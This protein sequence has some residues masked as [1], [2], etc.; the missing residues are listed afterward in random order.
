[1]MTWKLVALSTGVMYALYNTF[2]RLAAGKISDVYGALILE[3]TATFLLGILMLI[4]SLRNA[5]VT[6]LTADGLKYMIAAGVCVAFLSVLHLSTFRLG[7]A[8]SV[9]G[10]FILVKMS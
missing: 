8:L 5:E 2:V 3:I 10:P 4:M 1:M 6:Q 9:A 7:G